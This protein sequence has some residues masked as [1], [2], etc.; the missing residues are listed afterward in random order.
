MKDI[1]VWR[2][3]KEYFQDGDSFGGGDGNG[4]IITVEGF[5][6]EAYVML[7]TNRWAI[8]PDEIDEFCELLKSAMKDHQ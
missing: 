3:E 5:E 7:K 1:K 4:L 8:G 2:T 6:D